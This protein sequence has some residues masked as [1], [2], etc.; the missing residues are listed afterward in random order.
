MKKILVVYNTLKNGGVENVIMN[1]TSN[2]I[3]EGYQ[4]D[5]VT[6]DNA[7]TEVYNDK[8]RALG[9]TIYKVKQINTGITIVDRLLNILPKSYGLFKVLKSNKYNAVHSHQSFE[10]GL[11]MFISYIARVKV[12]ITHSHFG[13]LKAGSKIDAII[14]KINRG[15]ISKFATHK[16]ACSEN[17]YEW[18]FGL[19]TD[20]KV[21]IYNGIDL[22]E[23]DGKKNKDN[24]DTINFVNVGRYVE[25]KNHMFLL[26]IFKELCKFRDN[27]KLTLIGYGELK[28]KIIKKI[29]ELDLIEKVDLLPGNSNIVEILRR[30]DYSIFPSKREGFSVSL[31]EFQAMLIPVFLSSNIT[32][33]SDLGICIFIS[34]DDTPAIWARE[35]NKYISNDNMKRKVDLNKIDNKSIA[36][37]IIEIYK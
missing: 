33:E 8:F 10:S 16:V 30:Q 3:K 21:I 12:R 25:S 36:K 31:I 23:F 28:E 37:K 26:D 20:K 27:I 24:V 18:L 14:R 32:K 5:L 35:I 19:S 29:E 1:I 11:V 7:Q 13:G 22:G 17:A 4:F 15:L 2:I 6:F 9:G 34:L